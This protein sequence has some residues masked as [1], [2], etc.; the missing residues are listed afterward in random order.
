MVLDRDRLPS[1]VPSLWDSG[2]LSIG[3]D[4]VPALP[5]LDQHIVPLND[6]PVSEDRPVL[7]LVGENTPKQVHVGE[8]II[9]DPCVKEGGAVALVVD[10]AVSAGVGLGCS[11]LHHVLLGRATLVGEGVRFHC[12]SGRLDGRIGELKP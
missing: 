1:G 5:P 3:D 7:M 9:G 4:G 11:A 2:W 6:C 8:L 12:Q 10:Q